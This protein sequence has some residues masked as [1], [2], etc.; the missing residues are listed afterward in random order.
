MRF[1]IKD[2]DIATGGT[3]IVLINKSD[4][5]KY[6]LHAMDR[7]KLTRGRYSETALIDIGESEKA[8][9]PGKRNRETWI[10]QQ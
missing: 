10:R 4:A 8:V 6:D 7:V 2:M 3:L 1:K 9:P 5:A